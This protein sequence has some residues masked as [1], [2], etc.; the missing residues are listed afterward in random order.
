[1]TAGQSLTD[2]T[3]ARAVGHV[4]ADRASRGPTP[5]SCRATRPRRSPPRSPRSTTTSR[6]ATSRPGLRTGNLE[7]PVPR[8]GQPPA[9]HARRALAL[10]A[11][12][13]SP[14]RTCS[15]RASSPARSRHRQHRGRRAARD[16]RAALRVPAGRR[17]RRAGERPAHR[18]GH[19]AP[20]RELGRAVRADLLGG[21]PRSSTRFPD[22][23]VLSRRTR[24]R[25]SRDVARG[26]SGRR[27]SDRPDRAAGV[28]AVREAHGG[29]DADPLGLGRR[30]GG[31]A[32]ARQA[33][34]RAARG[35]RAARGGRGGRRQA[36][37]HRHRAHRRRGVAAAERRRRYAAMAKRANP[38][39][40]G[41]AAER[42]A[43]V[44]DGCSA[45]TRASRNLATI[46]GALQRARC[47]SRRSNT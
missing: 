26:A 42:I 12:R 38:F 31:G 44:L 17:R 3:V 34:A 1:M 23:H 13:A 45:T 24:T 5:C 15:P 6:W 14:R 46:R 7:H 39:G 20:P 36:R 22:T 2:I 21:R 25:S 35:D 33:G 40:D 27:S 41:H 16:G 43:G 4:A 29:L 8:G 11:H 18:A 30:A 10:R 19:G 28:P 37:R 32:D 47:P 9:H